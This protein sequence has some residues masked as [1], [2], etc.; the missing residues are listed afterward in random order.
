LT[1][2]TSS[3]IEDDRLEPGKPLARRPD[4]VD[5]VHLAAGHLDARDEDCRLTLLDEGERVIGSGG[6]AH[7]L[8][9]DLG[10]HLLDC[11]E[12]EGVL[13]DEYRSVTLGAHRKGRLSSRIAASTH[14]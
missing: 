2:S 13:V 3:Y 6:L 14:V 9:M 4:E 5:A 7:R 1:W 12:P 10:Q 11:F 8:H